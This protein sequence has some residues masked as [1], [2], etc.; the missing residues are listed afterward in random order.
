MKEE[1]GC[2]D[3]TIYSHVRVMSKDGRKWVFHAVQIDDENPVVTVLE[4]E[5]S[6]KDGFDKTFLNEFGKCLNESM[7]ANPAA[8][9]CVLCRSKDVDRWMECFSELLDAAYELMADPS[10][11]PVPLGDV[12]KELQLEFDLDTFGPEEA[13]LALN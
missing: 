4:S 12:P 13:D 5:A 8:T 2:L 3:S 10:V 7:P 9:A 1:H 11:K 6:G